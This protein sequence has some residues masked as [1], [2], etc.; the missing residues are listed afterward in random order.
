MTDELR[1][2]DFTFLLFAYLGRGGDSLIIF[3]LST[4]SMTQDTQVGWN[5]LAIPC[6]SFLLTS[7]NPNRLRKFATT[8]RD[9]LVQRLFRKTV[10]TL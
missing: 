6:H 7:E 4:R 9:D 1:I 8:V 2:Q 10:Y 5:F 3:F